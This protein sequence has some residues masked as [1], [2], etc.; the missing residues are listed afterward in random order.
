MTLESDLDALHRLLD[1]VEGWL[2]HSEAL[3]LCELA[4]EVERGNIVEIGSYHGR[5]T[6]A[7]A[8]GAYKSQSVVYAIDPHH[9]HEA[10]GYLFSPS[11]LHAFM[12]NLLKT[13]LSA[14]VR[15]INLSSDDALMYFNNPLTSQRPIEI[16]LLWLD[17]SHDYHDVRN[18]FREYTGAL[19][20]DGKVAIHDY[21]SWDGPTR[22]VD[23]ALASGVWEIDRQVD[24]TVVLRRT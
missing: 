23:E 9:A 13:N 7:L 24:N 4:Q 12:E 1:G 3:L 18:D 20:P 10:G 14:Y 19:L 2:G 21:G 8:Y 11:D 16:S 17:G 22:V 6:I 15:I 5:S